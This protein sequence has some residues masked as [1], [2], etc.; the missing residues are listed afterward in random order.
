[1]IAAAISTPT[2][3]ATD[4]YDAPTTADADAYNVC[5]KRIPLIVYCIS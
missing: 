2:T 3:A 1:M 5:D 4:D